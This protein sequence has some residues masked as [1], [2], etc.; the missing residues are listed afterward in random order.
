MRP[1]AIFL[2]LI[3]V[4]AL[5][6]LR[7]S[8]GYTIEQ[9]NGVPVCETYVENLN[10]FSP[11]GSLRQR[12][13]SASFPDLRKVEWDYPPEGPFPADQVVELFWNRD[14]NPLWYHASDEQAPWQGTPD[15]IANAKENYLRQIG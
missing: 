4:L 3:C 10:S 8:A 5:N 2:L 7:A 15:Q 14:A 11:R 13:I 9:G 12:Q 6:P 1:V